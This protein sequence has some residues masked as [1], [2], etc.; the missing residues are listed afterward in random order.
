MKILYGIQ[1]TGNGHIRRSLHLIDK[2]RQLGF[3]VDILTSGSGGDLPVEA[4]WKFTGLT[5]QYNNGSIDWVKTITKSN[6]ILLLRE[7][8]TQLENYD[9][10]ISDFEPISAYWA[11]RNRVKSIS[12]CNQNSI[13]LAGK[14]WT[15]SKWFIKSFA[16]CEHLIGYD[17]LEGKEVFQPICNISNFGKKSLT[18]F[19]IYL[20]Y[21]NNHKIKEI[22]QKTDFKAII[23]T[24][25]DI[26]DSDK[27]TIKRLSGDFTKDL[28]QCGSV[29]THSGFSTTSEALILGKRLWTI[30]V[31]GQLEQELNSKKLQSMGVFTESQ[32]SLS[33]L[34]IWNQYYKP[35]E[36]KWQDPTQAVI[37]KI[38]E[39][40]EKD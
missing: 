3:T 10:V 35:I 8:K 11:K 9:L 36:Y 19:L 21:L 26:Q 20:P 15:I 14:N 32:F 28:L 30:P 22:L 38:I 1:L 6:P 39:I 31:K 12:I 33:N 4:K 24:N 13:T 23:Y 29:I 18:T 37:K 17:Y 34:K 25:Q 40:Y 16:K 2:L 7:I 27:I 5:L